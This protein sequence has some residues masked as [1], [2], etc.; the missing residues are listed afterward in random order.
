MTSP[1]NF[2]GEI[3]DVVIQTTGVYEITAYGAQGGSAG[4]GAGGLGAEVQGTFTLT[5]GETLEILVGG[6]GS[7]PAGSGGGGGGGTFVVEAPAGGGGNGTPLIVA[8]GGGGGYYNGG[9]SYAGGSGQTSQSG[10]AGGGSGGAGGT[11][12]DGGGGSGT[13]NWTSGGGGYNSDGGGNYG[14]WSFHRGGVGGSYGG[15][16]YGGFGGGGYGYARGNGGGGG[17]GGGYSGGGGG[18]DNGGGGGGSFDA[19]SNQTLVAGENSGNGSVM[20]ELL[21]YLRG[22]HI[23]TPTGEAF[24]EDL[25][26]G[27]VVITRFGGIQPIKW[28]GRQ[29]FDARFVKDNREHLP[30]CIRGGALGAHLPARDLYVSPGHSMLLDGKLVLAAS[31]VNGLTITQDWSP[32]VIDYFQ[33]ELEAHDCVI[34][35]GTWSE[36]Y[37][38]GPGLR[39]CFHNA[40]EFAALY[41]NHAPPSELALCAP[42]PERGP[43]LAAALLPVVARAHTSLTPGPLRG[44]ID[45]VRAPFSIDCWAQDT[46]HP[47]LPVTLE[48]L[49]GD[50]V[51]ATVLACDYRPDLDQA[52]IANG[53]AAAFI[54][55]PVR[56]HPEQLKT[57]RIRRAS[58]HAELLIVPECRASVWGIEEE[59]VPM[60]IAA[61]A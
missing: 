12:G 56:L 21:C 35:E 45:T 50:D 47:R 2:T 15:P 30:V 14:G 23:L 32:P 57:L 7:G 51:I 38:D 36:T 43:K 27:D 58:D 34:A 31:L 18:Y 49:L 61:I 25:R 6:V 20:L 10:A 4:P 53:R 40:A 54:T 59:P 13:K 37:A 26:I 11:N 28:I 48:V 42:R 33:I 60:R 52:G 55:A 24:V 9:H 46:N 44:S 22:T 8:G 16:N 29:T 3:V 5:Q 19:G 1:Y 17:G 41:P 39:D